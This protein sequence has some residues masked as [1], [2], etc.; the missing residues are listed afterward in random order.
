MLAIG[1]EGSAN[2]LGVGIMLHPDDGSSP[3]VL[4]NVRHTYV[5]PP[6]EGFLPKDTARHHR[7]WVVRLVKRTLREARISPDDVDCIC[8]TQGPGMGAPLQS[9]AVAARMLSLLW[10]KPLVGVNHCVGHIEMGRLITGSTNPVV[11]YVSGG[12]TQ[13]IAYSSQRYRIFGET[14]DIAVGNCLDRFARTLHISNDP[15]PGYNIEQLAKKG[16]QLVELPYTVK[17]M[18][19]S[20]SGMLAAIDA[21]AASYGLDGPQSDEAVDANSPA[22]VE[23]GENGKPT[24][25]DLCF[26]LQET[27]FSML[28]EITERAMAHV[29]SKEVLIVGGV[30]CNE[31][32]QEMMGIMARDRGGSVHATDERFCI[33]NGIMIAQA[34]LLAY[35]TGFRTPLKESACTQRFRTDAVF[36]KWRD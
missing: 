6:G 34:G 2:K 32:L 29:G 20:F 33:D 5:S 9:V 14:L 17:G 22:A 10:K 36:V 25:A 35:K 26:S 3:Q 16:K 21:L 15:A 27:I 1:L 23:A 30:G 12:N 13:V 28:V 11:L 31:R 7:A 19:C 8:F 24:R 4:A 18:D